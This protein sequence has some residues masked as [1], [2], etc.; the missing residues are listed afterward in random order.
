MVWVFASCALAQPLA[1]P[2]T[3]PSAV[4]ESH[5]IIA[6][7]LS[8]LSA[9]RLIATVERL[10][11]FGTR[12]TLSSPDDPARGIGAARVWIKSE[13]ESIVQGLGD[14]ASVVLEEFDAPP[15]PRLPTGAKVVNVVA[16]IRGTDPIASRR[17]VYVVGHYDSRNA[18][19]LDASGDAPGAN[20]DASGCA[21]AMECLRLAASHP[22]RA[23]VVALFTAGEE[24]ALLGASFHASQAAAR[25]D[26]II[27]VLNNDIVGDPV[28]GEGS[29]AGN[30]GFVRV[31][32]EGLPRTLSAEELARMRSTGAESDS[33]SRQLARLVQEVGE[34]Q[35]LSVH[36]R[37]VYRSDRFLRGG[38]HTAFNERGFP[39]VR[40]TAA[41]ED[42]SRQHA[43]IEMHEGKPYGDLPAFID[44][45]YL[46]G[47][48]RANATA[49]MHLAMAPATPKNAR[50]VTAQLDTRTT[51]RWEPGD[52][53]EAC[54][55]QVVWRSTTESTWSHSIAVGDV[56][57]AIID[58]S[59]DDHFF[60]VR[61]RSPEGFL[62][63][64]AFAGAARE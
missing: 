21:V 29:R 35:T 2:Q 1:L 43:D 41:G 50:I 47:V 19:P 17:V 33:P 58:V 31:F 36:P 63:V 16:T 22:M 9:E 52:E 15:G 53:G 10:S 56:R 23:T 64:V 20:D 51:L 45:E 34:A 7:Q 62:S 12:H 6:R 14:R 54:D 11:A 49:F 28:V 26:R 40:F 18:D 4:A 13:L 60:G 44:R 30:A 32:S 55:Y 38:D 59:K 5:A 61:S 24:Q 57:E 46:L 3:Q 27:A 48:T 39:A 8:A 25:G 42:Y 37:L